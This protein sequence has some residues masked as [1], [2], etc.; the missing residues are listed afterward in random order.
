MHV[1]ELEFWTCFL[2]YSHFFTCPLIHFVQTIIIKPIIQREGH[3]HS[4]DGRK[5]ELYNLKVTGLSPNFNILHSL[6]QK[7]AFCL[8]FKQNRYQIHAK[9]GLVLVITPGNTVRIAD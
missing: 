6:V 3:F 4:E 2:Y 8:F 1:K 9:K 7:N 5:T